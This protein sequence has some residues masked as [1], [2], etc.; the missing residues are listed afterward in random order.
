MFH[1]FFS[2]SDT[3]AFMSCVVLKDQPAIKLSDKY[4]VTQ[5][6]RVVH[7]KPGNVHRVETH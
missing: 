6:K 4:D 3:I 7:L 5:A 1:R 2:A